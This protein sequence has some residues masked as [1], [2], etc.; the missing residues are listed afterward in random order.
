ML[1]GNIYEEPIELYTEPIEIAVKSLPDNAPPGFNGAV[2]QYEVKAWFSPE[3]AVVH[4]PSTLFVAISG[5][6][7]IRDLPELIWP[8]LDG[9]QAYN[10]LTS[11]TTAM[12]KNIMTGTRVYERVMVPSQIGE[13]IIP[14][15]TFVYFDPIAVEYRTINTEI[16]SAKVIPAPTPEPVKSGSVPAVFPQPT[17]AVDTPAPTTQ[18]GLSAW[19][20][21]LDLGRSLVT[22]VSVILLVGLCGVLPAALAFS[23]GGK[24]LWQR[25]T[26]LFNRVKA[27][28]EEKPKEES[29][30]KPRQSIHP[31]LVVAMQDNSDNYK[32]VSQALNTY[33][34][35][36]LQTSVNGLTRTELAARLSQYGLNEALIKRI[37]DC[38]AQSEIG[39]YGPVTEDVGW[40]LMVKTD[41]LL[42]DLD[43]RLAR[44]E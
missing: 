9:W 21:L 34:S 32:A 17:V 29:L 4:Q 41:A 43:K 44:E 12:E 24:W 18:V 37:E 16:L 3:V 5:I 15:I 27:E 38:L 13:F 31:A 30:Q 28:A 2:G 35:E 11:L 25:R 39:R 40:S 10:S 7:N 1:P 23:V 22:P 33:L 36:M 19:R 8:E 20:N 14:A 42:F 6:G 26:E